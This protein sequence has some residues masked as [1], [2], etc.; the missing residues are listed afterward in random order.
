M[1]NATVLAST[2]SQLDEMT[3]AKLDEDIP[4]ALFNE[5]IST[6]EV[7]ASIGKLK[8]GKSSGPDKIIGEMLKHA[9]DV[10]ID[11][12]VTLF[13]KL[14]D[15]GTFPQ[16]WSKS[17][18]VPIHKKGE[19]NQPDNYRGIALTSV[20][21][22]VYTHILNKRLSEW[23][24]MEGKIVEE[25]A[26]FRADYSTVDHIFTL[27]AIVQKFLLRHTK[28]Y[29][30]FV[31]FKKAFDSVNRNALWS[32]LRKSGVKGKLYKALRGI[33][34]SVVAC[35]RDKC[36]Y[37]DYFDCPRGVK[38]G[39]LLSPLMFSFFLSTN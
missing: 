34:D 23:A 27:Y 9:N 11:F 35:V 28:L 38:Q 12:L 4:E 3:N 33:Y 37:S 7:I 22:K 1:F 32:V 36:S 20:I 31:D 30:A 39:C 5:A 14:F 21:S 18:I 26:G 19:V 24:E 6:Q 2:V 17:I 16:E 29:V 15:H 13:N 25:Q 8:S 10:V